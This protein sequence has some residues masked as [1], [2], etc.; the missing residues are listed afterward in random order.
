MMVTGK[1]M[2]SLVDKSDILMETCTKDKWTTS[3][4]EI[5]KGSMFWEQNSKH[6]R[7]VGETTKKRASV[8]SS[9]MWTDK[10]LQEKLEMISGKEQI[11]LMSGKM[12]AK[13]FAVLR[14]MFLQKV[15]LQHQI[16]KHFSFKSSP[17]ND[18]T[19]SNLVLL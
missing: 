3:L 13:Q 10:N 8:W 19:D 16:T 11:A 5:S 2:S 14:I 6:T 7:E 1:T 12:D 15:H 9:T 4:K 18:L 17:I